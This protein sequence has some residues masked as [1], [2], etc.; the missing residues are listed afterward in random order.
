[1]RSGILTYAVLFLA[2]VMFAS[3]R[4]GLVSETYTS[5]RETIAVSTGNTSSHRTSLVSIGIFSHNATT[6]QLKES[7]QVVAAFGP[8]P[9]VNLRAPVVGIALSN[10]GTLPITSV[11]VTFHFAG[12]TSP[13]GE[14]ARGYPFNF[15]VSNSNPLMP[16]QSTISEQTLA[17]ATFQSFT[18][19][20]ATV[21][22]IVQGGAQFRHVQEVWITPLIYLEPNTPISFCTGPTG[23]DV[24]FGADYSSAEIFNCASQAA[25]QS[26]CTWKI[27]SPSDP[28]YGSLVTV[29]YSNTSPDGGLSSCEY[30]DNGDQGNYYH[31][32][33]VATSS[34]SFII[35][36][37]APPPMPG[38]FGPHG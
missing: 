5:S 31:A 3:G 24:C 32:Y 11:V 14:P 4:V 18:H 29:R 38:T 34:T 21:N 20:P 7:A 23:Y 27:I 30:T 2:L 12:P 16:G 1:M 9:P 28:Q 8:I 26:G 13:V 17:G 22:G 15:D 25:S 33:C 37:H 19:Y 6:S 10:A 36:K 35:T